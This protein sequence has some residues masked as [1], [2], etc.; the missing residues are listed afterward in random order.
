MTARPDQSQPPRNVTPQSETQ[1]WDENQ[2]TVAS[3]QHRQSGNLPQGSGTPMGTEAD[4]PVMSGARFGRHDGA[5]EG[6][7]P[8]GFANLRTGR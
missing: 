2:G 6:P 1:R 4:V 7:T 5:L 8:A 3:E